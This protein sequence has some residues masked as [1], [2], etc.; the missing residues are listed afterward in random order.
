ML[1]TL[2]TLFR[3]NYHLFWVHPGKT[4]RLSYELNGTK[5]YAIYDQNNNK[6]VTPRLTISAW[7]ETSNREINQLVRVK[8]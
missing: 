8:I 6:R 3:I 2:F 5:Y 4:L 7:Q 1:K